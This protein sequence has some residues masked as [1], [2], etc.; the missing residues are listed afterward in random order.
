LEDHLSHTGP[1][2]GTSEEASS[3]LNYLILL[4]IVAIAAYLVFHNK[5]K[6]LFNLLK[7]FFF[8]RA[9]I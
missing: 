6:V 5:K 3:Y 1:K 8:D 9:L 4:S 2:V 7:A